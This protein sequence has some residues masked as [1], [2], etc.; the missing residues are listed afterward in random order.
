MSRLTANFDYAGWWRGG[1]AFVACVLR[2]DG[3]VVAESLTEIGYPRMG[4]MTA[5]GRRP[6]TTF[7]ELR[8]LHHAMMLGRKHL[9]A[10][11]EV[12]VVCGDSE[13]AVKVGSGKLNSNPA[14]RRLGVKILRLIS[15]VPV[16]VVVQWVPREQNALAHELANSRIP[17]RESDEPVEAGVERLL[18]VP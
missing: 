10:K 17:R 1:V 5:R 14:H 9:I 11:D 2:R 12:L 4:A 16:R 18:D 3:D 15:E 6:D 13:G 8:A 7:G